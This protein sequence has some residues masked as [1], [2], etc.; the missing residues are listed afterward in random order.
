MKKIII[1]GVAIVFGATGAFAAAAPAND[2]TIDADKAARAE[3]RRAERFQKMDANKDHGISK[4]EWLAQAKERQEKA[5]AR[6]DVNHDGKLSKE[7]LAANSRK[8]DRGSHAQLAE[9]KMG[10]TGEMKPATVSTGTATTTTTSTA[11][12]TT[13]AVQ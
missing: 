2:K 3:A 10:K 5:F 9:H 11:A 1:A 12:P 13:P 8:G 4:D 6:L 7:E